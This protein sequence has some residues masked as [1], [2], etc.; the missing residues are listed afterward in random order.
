MKKFLSILLSVVMVLSI[1]PITAFAAEVEKIEYQPRESVFAYYET[2]GEW[3]KGNDD[4]EDFFYY[5][6]VAGYGQND[7]MFVTYSN[8]ETVEYVGAY[9]DTGFYMADS[10]G[11]RIDQNDFSV[12]DDQ[13]DVHWNLGDNNYYYI[14]YKTFT[15]PVQV[16]I[17]KNPIKA[18]SYTPAR[19]LT[20]TE[21]MGGEWRYDNDDIAYYDYST[22]DFGEGDVIS[23]TFTD[24]G[25]TV[26]YTY[27]V[28]NENWEASGFYNVEGDML[29]NGELYRVHN[30]D[31]IWSVGSDNNYYYV[32]YKKVKS[33]KVFVEVVEN[34]VSRI[35]FKKA[36]DVVYY[37]GSNMYYDS[38]DGAYYYNNPNFELGDQLTVF[39]RYGTPTVYTYTYDEEEGW[40]NGSFTSEGKEDISRDDVIIDGHQ[41]TTPWV[42]GDN[43]CDVKYMG[44]TA[45]FIVTIEENP[46]SAIKFEKAKA[47]SYYE[48]SNMYY[49]N[50]DDAYYY[51][52]PNFDEGD[53]LTVYDS[54]GNSK[55]YV[56]STSPWQFNGPDGE[57]IKTRDIEIRNNQNKI[58]W[59]L[60]SDNEV[61][62]SYMGRSD[63]FYVTIVQNPVT[64]ISFTAT[65]STITENTNG[66]NNIDD[67]GN[68]YYYYFEPYFS[69]GD[70][71]TVNYSDERGKVNYT[72]QRDGYE[73]VFISNSGERIE[74][75]EV[76]TSSNQSNK[77]WTVGGDNYYTVSYLGAETKVGVSIVVNPIKAVN[78][79]PVT[80]AV[81]TDGQ[82]RYDEYD[83][84]YYF[85]IP[86]IKPGDVLTIEYNDDRGTVAYTAT[87][88]SQNERTDF[89]GTNGDV[90]EYDGNSDFQAYSY[91]RYS[92]WT[93]GGEFN[94]YIFEYKSF[95]VEVPV[96]IQENNV[97]AISITT[98]KPLT[99]Y[100]N[101]K[102]LGPDE[103]GAVYEHYNVPN[104]P[105]G[106]VLTIT[107][108][109]DNKKEYVLGFDESD[110]ERYFVNG[111][112]KIDSRDIFVSHNQATQ[113]WT[114]GSENYF[115]A[116]YLGAKCQIS[117]TIVES[118]VE[119]ISYQRKN[120]VVLNEFDNGEWA[121]NAEGSQFYNYRFSHCEE[122]D[123]LTVN[124]TNGTSKDF[125]CEFDDKE[126]R[127]SFVAGDGERLSIDDVDI[128]D[129]QWDEP[130]SAGW[131]NVYSVTFRGITTTVPV[132]VQHT[133]SKNVI[134]PTCTNEGYTEYECTACGEHFTDDFKNPL[135]HST[136][137]VVTKATLSKDGK[138]SKVCSRCGKTVSTSAVSRPNTFKLANTAYQYTGKAITPAV[139][140]TDAKGKKIAAGNYTLKY[141]NN[142]NVGTATVS[143]SFKGNYSGTKKLE[144]TINPK[145]TKLSKLTSGKKKFT[146]Q[147]SKQAT[148]TTGYE[149]QYS[150]S[151]KFSKSTTKSVTVN[152]KTTK[153]EF[154]KLSAKKK[155]YVRIR[156]YKTVKGKKYYSS[157]SAV[158]SVTTGK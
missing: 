142:K 40:W 2:N 91:Q 49:D 119:S 39:D 85:D 109:S 73:L 148:Q 130:W 30:G 99:L 9:D 89:V 106:T 100:A 44:Y 81:F 11:N 128:R 7:K 45:P 13:Q 79:T 54:K 88:D 150:T 129:N 82:Q 67:E 43:S 4:S 35:E 149:I 70:V 58:P 124:Y 101:E 6:G 153:K 117:V 137:N 1:L 131:D 10:N 125:V 74:T 152:N 110:H 8:G 103:N 18:I 5:F 127:E 112:E 29:D 12:R 36:N 32:E 21:N 139:T 71:L 140:V 120:P 53:K 48:G 3:R 114:V 37:E 144:Y 133:F 158:K 113:P 87:Y 51:E 59:T 55:V 154:T 84:R 28:N 16:N 34:P 25:E 57:V 14:V 26:D 47:V 143:I 50:W 22:P 72:A 27:T 92:P 94:Y 20:V 65:N 98:P 132:T 66:Y 41:N 141:D 83:G 78:F 126:Q 17:I 19:A 56:F 64:S 63:S 155:Y 42:V 52:N 115:T 76:K 97:K 80:P 121:T 108:K 60:G 24:S 134:K 90:I 95:A 118:D 135:G 147:W 116:S 145:G 122:G 38:W 62:V 123:I 138:I 46:V 23:V 93:V 86:R 68:E 102:V 156:T 75:Y 104:L 69:E 77:H 96:T 136:K 31:N 157:W 15:A 61:T 107:D 146:A 33:D 151:N 105:D 111:N